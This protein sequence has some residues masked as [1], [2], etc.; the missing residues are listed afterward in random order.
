MKYNIQ[1]VTEI[2]KQHKDSTVF[3]L[4]HTDMDG[5]ISAY[6]VE[7]FFED[8]HLFAADYWT[9]DK[10]IDLMIQA[11][12]TNDSKN[13]SNII[14]V[15]D[16]NIT[17]RQLLI[18]EEFHT[19]VVLDHHI[20]GEPAALLHNNYLLD[21]TRSAALITYDTLSE[22]FNYSEQK[23]QMLAQ[24]VSIYDIWQ[25][26]Q[27]PQ[28]HSRMIFFAGKF[29]ETWNICNGNYTLIEQYTD[30][31]AKMIT[32]S[33]DYIEEPIY[34]IE[35]DYITKMHRWLKEMYFHTDNNEQKKL[36]TN[37]NYPTDI[38]LLAL[39]Y[40][41]FIQKAEIIEID[42]IR[43]F[44]FSDINSKLFQYISNW[45]FQDPNNNFEN[46]IMLNHNTISG[47]VA[48]RSKELDTTPY[49]KQLGGGGH[50]CSSGASFKGNTSD[51]I[52]KLKG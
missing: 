37:T 50:K 28:I 31:L 30:I 12:M 39:H 35:I 51:L 49:A 15:T 20:T 21:D 33:I 2:L 46:V 36:L 5:W 13:N 19:V 18:L 22:A 41:T 47:S 16:L 8:V 26:H 48:L 7:H 34:T 27:Y 25:I 42:G 4:T 17:E 32:Y 44:V 23:L 11:I 40:G 29:K 43:L 24:A 52:V 45:Q 3:N 38:R 1:E 6:M 10:D 9:I 14:I